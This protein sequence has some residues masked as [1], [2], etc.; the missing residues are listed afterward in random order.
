MPG[1]NHFKARTFRRDGVGTGVGFV[2]FSACVLMVGFAGCSSLSSETPELTQLTPDP[3]PDAGMDPGFG[4]NPDGTYG[5][6]YVRVPRTQE[7]VHVDAEQ[8]PTSDRAGRD[9]A[10]A[11][12]D[13]LPEVGNILDNINAPGQLVWRKADGTETV[14]YDCTGAN[15]AHQPS[16]PRDGEDTCIPMDPAVSYDGREVV[17]SVFHGV[18]SDVRTLYRG[19]SYTSGLLLG[20]RWAQIYVYNFVTGELRAWP[21]HP[22]LGIEG[23]WDTAPVWLPVEPGKPQQ[24]MFTSTRSGTFQHSVK[25]G[26]TNNSRV[27]QLWIANADG[28]NARNVGHQDQINALHPFVH[29]SGRVIY[30]THQITQMQL[31]GRTQVTANNMWWLASVDRR[32]GDFNAHMHAHDYM[33]A[34]SEFGQTTVLNA[35]HF[36]AERSNGDVCVDNY[37]RSNNFGAGAILCWPVANA[38]RSPLGHEGTF[39][40]TQPD[41][42]YYAVRGDSNDAGGSGPHVRD[43]VGIPNGGLMFAGAVDI[44]SRCNVTADESSIAAEKKQTCDMGIYTMEASS[45]ETRFQDWHEDYERT[46]GSIRIVDSPNW[47]EIQPR[48]VLPYW[49][50]FG[51]S[52]PATPPL[53]TTGSEDESWGVFESADARSGNFRL[54]RKEGWRGPSDNTWCRLHGCA[55]Q[56]LVTQV[57]DDPAVDRIESIEAVRFWAAFPNTRAYPTWGAPKNQQ[58]SPMDSN[59]GQRVKLLGDVKVQ[60]DGSF[61]AKI[62]AGVPFFMAGV[63]AKGRSVARHKHVMVMQPGEKMRCGGCHLHDTDDTWNAQHAFA[64]TRAAELGPQPL[65]VTPGTNKLPEWELDIYPMLQRDCKSCHNGASKAPPPNFAAGS[66]DLYIELTNAGYGTSPLTDDGTTKADQPWMTRYINAYFSRASLLYWKAAG[67]RSDG[68]ADDDYPLRDQSG[69]VIPGT[70][71]FNYEHPELGASN[72]HRGGNY[73]LSLGDLRLLSD[74]I[75]AG[76]YRCHKDHKDPTCGELTKHQ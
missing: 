55:L 8:Y 71:D 30:S 64:N 14:I 12:H 22:G 70:G 51:N 56:N 49:A 66:N 37:Y 57:S 58:Q 23:V 44:N 72:G 52:Q 47:H 34:V 19:P 33:N 43:P 59:L 53:S 60:A 20:P 42:W 41:S 24:V 6:V 50:V 11:L 63:D 65:V 31:W 48:P 17:F 38:S 62:P 5:I 26:G 46:A 45:I 29:S 73:N 54:I 3:K 21:A 9:V 2:L 4:L 25:S 18:Y 1:I 27:L 13:R 75:E 15:P 76:A 16:P 36:I 28:T 61:S 35:L 39:P 40:F 68:A 32:G 74:W 67:E 10:A 69:K 7:V